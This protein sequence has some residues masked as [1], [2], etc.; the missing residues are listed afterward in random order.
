LVGMKNKLILFQVPSGEMMW[1]DDGCA[2]F[3]ISLEDLKNRNFDNV[4]FS[5]E[6]G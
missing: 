2:H 5:W 6:C 4:I 1:G 3:F